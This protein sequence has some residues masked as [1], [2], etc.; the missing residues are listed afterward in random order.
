ML[1]ILSMNNASFIR[2]FKRFISR[3]GKPSV[4]VHDNFKTF[5]SKVVKRFML[6]LEIK[7][8]F[9]LPASPW[10]GG[11][12]ER[13]VRSVKLSL[14]KTLGRSLLTY[15]ELETVLYDVET[16][17]NSRPLTC[18]SEDEIE[19]SLTPY[20][21]MFGRNVMKVSTQNEYCDIHFNS[22]E[23]SKRLKYIQQLLSNYWK[24][25]SRT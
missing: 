4:T 21:L 10:W 2:V 1:F 8:R 13:L 20:H 22:Q 24:R 16:V 19:E 5:K 17:I 25:F 14:R 9:I 15:E 18:I 11:F 6:Q 3:K 12:Y 7:Q 23:C